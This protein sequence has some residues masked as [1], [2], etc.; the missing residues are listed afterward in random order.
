MID[1]VKADIIYIDP[2]YPGTMNNYYGFYGFLDEYIKGEKLE[3]FRN[4]FRDKQ[5]VISQFEKLFSKMSDFKYWYISYNNS[6]YP[7]KEMMLDILSKY[8][9]RVD[10]VEKKHNYQISG[11]IYKNNNKEYLFMAQT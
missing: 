1:K 10:V 3:P 11:K 4:D 2:P 5:Y 8:T 6:S 9:K 7:N